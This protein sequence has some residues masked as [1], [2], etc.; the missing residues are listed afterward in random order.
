SCL[1]RQDAERQGGGGG[2][3][4]G[5]AAPPVRHGNGH[6]DRSGTAG[7]TPPPFASS[8]FFLCVLCGKRARYHRP[9]L[10]CPR[11][12]PVRAAPSCAFSSSR[13]GFPSRRRMARGCACIISC[14]HCF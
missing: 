11:P 7:P 6:H 1:P 5:P 9:H 2:G 4:G 13:R 10:D 12:S 3:G 14:V 8:A